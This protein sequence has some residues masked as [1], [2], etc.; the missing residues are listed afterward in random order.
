MIVAPI[1]GIEQVDRELA[2][3]APFASAEAAEE[4][5]ARLLQ[6]WHAL[7]PSGTEGAYDLIG[8]RYRR[9][10]ERR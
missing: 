1:T 8:R 9:R 10:A 3:R 7:Q 5:A 4:T 6:V 2:R